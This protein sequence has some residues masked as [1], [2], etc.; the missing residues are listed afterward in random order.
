[1]QQCYISCLLE[2][3]AI[4]VFALYKPYIYSLLAKLTLI[5]TVPW[6]V[7]VAAVEDQRSPPVED[8]QLVVEYLLPDRREEELIHLITSCGQVIDVNRTGC[9]RPEHC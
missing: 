7:D 9:V 6:M 8:L 2:R 1:M 3:L 5:V 4:G